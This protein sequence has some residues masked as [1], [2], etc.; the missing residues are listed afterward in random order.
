MVN[1]KSI[2]G[3]VYLAKI[4]DVLKGSNPWWT[5]N[6]KVE[7]KER[8]AY[9]E[10]QKFISLPQMIALTG[11]RGVGKTTLMFKLVEDMIKIGF[12][13]K[14]IIYFSFDEFREVEIRDVMSTYEELVEEFHRRKVSAVAG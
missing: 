14:N 2:L 1:V 10:I 9:A 13:P 5:E 4:C 3:Y 6:F 12:D 8:E 7:F 11:L